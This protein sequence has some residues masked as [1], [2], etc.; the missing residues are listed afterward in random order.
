MVKNQIEWLGLNEVGSLYNSYLHPLF[1]NTT[2][3]MAMKIGYR[4]LQCDENIPM[5]DELRRCLRKTDFRVFF[6]MVVSSCVTV[7]STLISEGVQQT[8]ANLSTSMYHIHFV[9]H[10][11]L[12]NQPLFATVIVVCPT[13]KCSLL[14]SA[15]V[16]FSTNQI[17][18]RL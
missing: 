7:T 3:R 12:F 6:H 5:L 14:I 10:T 17:A 9:L 1:C 8:T 18:L 16:F 15:P 4:F 2:H 11:I 13:S